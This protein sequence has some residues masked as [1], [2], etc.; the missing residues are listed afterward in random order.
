MMKV[1]VDYSDKESEVEMY[2]KVTGD[3]ENIK[4]N[5]ILNKKEIKD[6]QNLLQE[7]HVSENIFEYV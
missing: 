3:F 1:N 6:I 7:I 4:I 5:K 2:K